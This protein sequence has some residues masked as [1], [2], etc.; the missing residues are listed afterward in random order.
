MSMLKSSIYQH[1]KENGL[2]HMYVSSIDNIL[3]KIC[4]PF[5]VGQSILRNADLTFKYVTKAYPSENVG[6]HVKLNNGKFGVMGI[7]IRIYQYDAGIES[8]EKRR[9]RFII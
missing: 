8:N 7:I 9:R 3:N 4:D 1:A 5:L 6:L 2:T